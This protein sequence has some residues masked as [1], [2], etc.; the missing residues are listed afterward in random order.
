MRPWAEFEKQLEFARH[1]I[2]TGFCP[3]GVNTPAKA[4]AIMQ[5][6]REIGIPPLYALREIAVVNG[7]PTLSG[8]LM[9]ALM[10]RAGIQPEWLETT[11]AKATL[12][13]TRP[14]GVTFSGSFT[15][16]E[17]GRA[18]LLAK[19]GAVW[20]QYPAAMLRWRTVSLVAH[21]VA[22]D[23]VAGFYTPEEMGA[24]VNVEGEITTVGPLTVES[25]PAHAAIDGL[26]GS[27]FQ[28][29]TWVAAFEGATSSDQVEA[30]WSALFQDMQGMWLGFSAEQQ[31]PIIQA[32]QRARQ[33]L[34]QA[35]KEA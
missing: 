28:S 13:A 2:A 29:T 23:V 16:E 9:L 22:P 3:T 5:A 24:E 18:G 14:N 31:A 26:K 12:K 30:L 17:A 33:R 21:L 7:R 35:Q 32:R 4:V 19:P 27:P 34:D 1:M 10:H 15:I 20:R 25:T 6:G 8:K 11:D